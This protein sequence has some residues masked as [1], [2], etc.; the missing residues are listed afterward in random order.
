[1]LPAKLSSAL[2]FESWTKATTKERKALAAAVADAR[3]DA[4]ALLRVDAGDLSLPVFAHKESGVLLHL[5]PGGRFT[6]GMTDAELARLQARYSFYNDADEADACLDGSELR[7]ATSID[8]PAFLL[9]ARPLGGRQLEWLLAPPAER[10][11][12][13]NGA[14]KKTWDY[15]KVAKLPAAQYLA[16]LD[17]SG[18]GELE[19]EQV[20]RAEAALHAIGLRLPSEAEWERAARGGDERAFANGDAI[21]STPNTGINPFGFAD[22]GATADVCADGWCDSLE[23]VPEDGSARPPAAQRAVRGGAGLCYPWQDC[24][25]WTLL[26]CASRKSLETENGLLSIRPAMSL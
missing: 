16:Y 13:K 10:A 15:A 3:A 19:N 18:S 17:K 1:M 21:P 20:G 24:A 26:V 23:G 8:L 11:E 2:R 7:P 12:S 25:E 9:A 6:M 5:V 22:M 14:G 4:I